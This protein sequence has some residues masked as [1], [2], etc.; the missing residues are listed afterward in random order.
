MRN[1]SACALNFERSIVPQRHWLVRVARG[2]D[3]GS[4]VISLCVFKS[5][6]TLDVITGLKQTRQPLTRVCPSHCLI[7]RANVVMRA[8]T[9][10]NAREA[11]SMELDAAHAISIIEQRASLGNGAN[12]AD[13][14]DASPQRRAYGI[15]Y[16]GLASASVS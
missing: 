16:G 4:L 11:G 13:T 10:K 5:S 3:D 7:G 2:A 12:C 6:R 9:G 8:E 14:P 1:V 15:A